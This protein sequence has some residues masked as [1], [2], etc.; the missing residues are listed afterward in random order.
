[1][2]AGSFFPEIN[3]RRPLY[4]VT[5]FLLWMWLRKSWDLYH[6][7]R[8]IPEANAH[9]TG[10]Q[11][12]GHD[13]HNTKNPNLTVDIISIGSRQRHELLDVQRM[14]FA[15]HRTVRNF[16]AITEDDDDDPECASYLTQQSNATSSIREMCGSA[17]F[18]KNRPMMRDRVRNF[19]FRSEY[20]DQKP[21]EQLAGWMCAQKRPVMGLLKA[22]VQYRGRQR[23]QE[24]PDFLIILDDDTYY[25]MDIFANVFAQKDPK[26]TAMTAGCIFTSPIR[27]PQGG[28]GS[29]WTKGL[30]NAITK[31]IDCNPAKR[32]KSLQ[33]ICNYIQENN[34]GERRLFQDSMSLLDIVGAYT[35]QQS[36]TDYQ[37]WTPEKGGYCLHSDLLWGWL[38]LMIQRKMHPRLKI[39]LWELP[40]RSGMFHTNATDMCANQRD[41]CQAQTPVCHYQS[42]ESMLRFHEE[43]RLAFNN[44]RTIH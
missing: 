35:K 18:H 26:K 37:N 21:K 12:R 8:E 1:M 10:L 25:N 17:V 40:S 38:M 32:K 13:Y 14:T 3:G 15:T 34:F 22:M 28:I 11:E 42:A 19:V 5:A 7:S 43:N 41:H 30:L 4:F 20:L 33:S 36:F 31:P 24:F 16:F 44:F 29:I 27:Y 23:S 6:L 39:Q 2:P 9:P